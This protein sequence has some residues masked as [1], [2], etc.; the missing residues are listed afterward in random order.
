MVSHPTSPYL[1]AEKP[2]TDS[3]ISRNQISTVAYSHPPASYR[4][5][6]RFFPALAFPFPF[7]LLPPFLYASSSSESYSSG[8]KNP[9]SSS[10][11]WSSPSLAVDEPAGVAA[12][13][14]WISSENLPCRILLARNPN[15]NRS[16]SIVL[17]LPEPF[18]PTIA[19]KDCVP[20]GK[21]LNPSASDLF[22]TIIRV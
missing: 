6:A 1:A 20:I 18:G 5:V 17:D 3:I 4:S 19:E 8:S 21:H 15:T 9:S 7:P 14:L 10:S 13:E 16:A 2:L 12:P 11:S 22:Q